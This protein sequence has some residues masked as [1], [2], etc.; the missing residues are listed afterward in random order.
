MDDKVEKLMEIREVLLEK[1]ITNAYVEFS[2]ADF[3]RLLSKR[4]KRFAYQDSTTILKWTNISVGFVAEEMREAFEVFKTLCSQGR[5]KGIASDIMERGNFRPL[6]CTE[7]IFILLASSSRN[8]YRLKLSSQLRKQQKHGELIG[9]GNERGI[10]SNSGLGDLVTRWTIVDCTQLVSHT[11]EV[12]RKTTAFLESKEVSKTFLTSGHFELDGEQTEFGLAGLFSILYK[13]IPGPR[14]N[15]I[16]KYSLQVHAS[17]LCRH[18][19][20]HILNQGGIENEQRES[21]GNSSSTDSEHISVAIDGSSSLPSMTN[22]VKT[23]A[24]ISMPPSVL[25]TQLPIQWNRM[26]RPKVCVLKRLKR[27]SK[28]TLMKR[29]YVILEVAVVERMTNYRLGN[30]EGIALLKVEG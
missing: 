24:K 22:Q 8:T 30:L 19:E 23:N 13:D 2:K 7:R 1:G 10:P 9:E 5:G 27:T 20:S 3:T 16:P 17:K 12:V 21:G 28:I 29:Q 15:G 26:R 25:P 11:Q 18:V 14:S 6:G 4:S